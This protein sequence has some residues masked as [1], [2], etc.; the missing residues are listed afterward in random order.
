MCQ[1]LVQA[2]PAGLASRPFGDLGHDH[3]LARHLVRGQPVECKAP[4]HVPGYR[5]SRAED[6]GRHYIFPEPRVRR[7]KRDRLRNVRVAKDGLIHLPRGDLLSA[8]VDQLLDPAG[9]IEVAP[10]VAV[11]QVAGAKPAAGERRGVRLGVVLVARHDVRPANDDLAGLARSEQAIRLAHDG[12][13]RSG[14]GPTDPAFRLAGGSGLLHIWCA[15]SVMPYDSSTGT[16]KTLSSSC[17]TGGGSGDDDDR[18]SRRQCPFA[19]ACRRAASAR[20][21]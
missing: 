10:G 3:N 13:F 11:S 17:R 5:L 18:I 8:A 16:P 15:A 19:A 2:D 20:T 1:D 6:D 21:A 12:N 4:E 9:D 7:R 14:R